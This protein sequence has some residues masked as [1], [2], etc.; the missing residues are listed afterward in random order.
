[1]TETIK[2]LNHSNYMF[3]AKVMSHF[4]YQLICKNKTGYSSQANW[5]QFVQWQT[6]ENGRVMRMLHQRGYAK[7]F[8]VFQQR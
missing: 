6:R 3:V 1:M 2:V 8:M 7:M 5:L 4:F